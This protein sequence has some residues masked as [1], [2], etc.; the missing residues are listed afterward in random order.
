MDG[1]D[2]NRRVRLHITT[3]GIDDTTTSDS[4]DYRTAAPIH[5]N[6]GADPPGNYCTGFTGVCSTATEL[7]SRPTEYRYLSD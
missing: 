5:S 1:E 7:D 4:D 3:P 6:I 2:L